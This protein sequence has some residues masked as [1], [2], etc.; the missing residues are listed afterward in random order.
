MR[1]DV[2]C[3]LFPWI[4]LVGICLETTLH[5]FDFFPS[6]EALDKYQ[7]SWSPSTHGSLFIPVAET[8]PKGQLSLT[9]F[10]VGQIG[11]G[12]YHNTF[13]THVS[14]STVNTNSVVPGGILSYGLTKHINIGGGLSAIYWKATDAVSGPSSSG[15]LG[16]TSL[17]LTART[18]VQDPETW[19]PSLSLYSRISL[20]TSRW[21]GTD[22][23]PGGFEP[24]SIR[25]STRFGALSLTEG[26]LV[27]KNFQPVRV[28]SAIYY[29]YNTPGSESGESTTEYPGDLL[30][31]RVS[32]E[33]VFDEKRGFGIL[34]G[35]LVRQG[36][37]YRLDGHDIN[38]TPV[39]FSLV[40]LSLGFEYRMT[41]TL[42]AMVG[43]L[44]TVA[45]QND[46][47][48][49]YPGF[50]LKYYWPA[51]NSNN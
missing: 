6:D 33:Y 9:A 10:T 18:L 42:L 31:V 49:F 16:D 28:T 27:T 45:G 1:S 38:V 32:G 39:N 13:T 34:F 3:G 14:P 8:L 2:K 4:L 5:A 23:P 19:R 12:Q 20:P 50:S 47:H 46:V 37:P 11:D 35:G 17:F 15:G 36:L 29:T 51:R 25:P 24:F 7:Q 21:S 48:A 22:P 40:G 41:P 43:C 44:F 30:D 26:L